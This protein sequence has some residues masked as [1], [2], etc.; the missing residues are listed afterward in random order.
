[1]GWRITGDTGSWTRTEDGKVRSE[2]NP[3]LLANRK[4]KLS[5]QLLKARSAL[6]KVKVP[7]LDA[8]FPVSR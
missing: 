5:H 7:W 6:A 2:D 8:R 4:R 1:M 3:V